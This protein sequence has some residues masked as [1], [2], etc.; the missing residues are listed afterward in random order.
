MSF[1]ARRGGP[2]G[3]IIGGDGVPGPAAEDV[4]GLAVRNGH[5]PGRDVGIRR[6][7]GIGLQR[8]QEGFRPR[9]VAVDGTDDDPADPQH[10]GTVLGDHGLEGLFER[11]TE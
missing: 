3:E 8:R 5:Q 7:V 6:Q 4:D 11:H 10:R 9:I 2:F 1:I